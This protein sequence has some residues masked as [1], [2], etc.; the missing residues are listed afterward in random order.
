M[1][2]ASSVFILVMDATFCR[3]LLIKNEEVMSSSFALIHVEFSS[4]KKLMVSK[5]K[6][7]QSSFFSFDIYILF[8]F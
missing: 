2:G 6:E 8:I 5:N 3:V 1:L 4:H 7:S